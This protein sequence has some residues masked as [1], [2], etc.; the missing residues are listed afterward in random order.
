MMVSEITT[1]RGNRAQWNSAEAS[2]V[3]D[4]IAKFKRN[5]PTKKIIGL[6]TAPSIHHQ[7]EQNLKLNARKEN[8]GIL[9]KPCIDFAKLL[10][11]IDR[12]RLKN[13]LL[14]EVDMQLKHPEKLDLFFSDIIPN[15]DVD[16]EDK[17]TKCLPVYSL[18]AVATAFREQQTPELIGWKRLDGVR[19]LDK[20]MFIA[21]VV[22]K[23]ME[24]TIPDG[25]YC[26]FRYDQGGSRN[27]KVVLVESRQ[28]TDP[29][30]NQQ[31]TI[32][33]YR[34]EKEDLGSGRWR[35]KK[36]MLSPDNKTFNDII[37]EDVT[38]ADF[39]VIAEFIRAL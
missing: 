8:V 24:P 6:F 15:E 30:T 27:G 29:E 7:L 21:Q 11:S 2:S 26:I 25:S 18:Q 33:R 31:F 39:R 22:G 10:A 34:S 13:M 14:K 32:K 35:H 19:K 4:H 36:I 28:V 23:S 9:F 12:N 38:G 17:H 16:E 1:F 37:L 20:H 3:P 5:N